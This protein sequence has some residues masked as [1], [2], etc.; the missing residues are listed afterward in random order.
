MTALIRSTIPAFSSHVTVILDRRRRRSCQSC[1]NT[2]GGPLTDSFRPHS[3]NR[4][5]N[6]SPIH[7]VCNFLMVLKVYFFAIRRNVESDW[8]YISAFCLICL[9]VLCLIPLI[10]LNC[11]WQFQAYFVVRL[12]N[13]ISWTA[14]MVFSS[15]FVML[16]S[17]CYKSIAKA[18][19]SKWLYPK[20]SG[21]RRLI[22][23][24]LVRFVSLKV[25]KF[26]DCYFP[27]LYKSETPR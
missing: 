1:S 17:L 22:N 5:S 10:R 2:G 6:D 7:V 21:F 9:W 14:V 4:L 26:Y 8:F 18:T 23:R 12:I 3:S 11:L 24:M 27:P 16:D 20:V 19:A 25:K 15:A 13:L